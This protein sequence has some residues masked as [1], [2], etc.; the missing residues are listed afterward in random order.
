MFL[1]V[2]AFLYVKIF[3]VSQ[4]WHRLFT[5]GKIAMVIY[6]GYYL[7]A[8]RYEIY[9]RVLKNVSLENKFRSH[10]PP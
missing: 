2:F 1:R 8:R 4:K 6:R 9:F 5:T 10:A 3:Q 7:A